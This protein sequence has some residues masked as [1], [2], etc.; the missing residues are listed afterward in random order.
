MEQSHR[1]GRKDGVVHGGGKNYKDC[2]QEIARKSFFR[3][4]LSVKRVVCFSRPESFLPS[5]LLCWFT[6]QDGGK[7]NR[8]NRGRKDVA[9]QTGRGSRKKGGD[10]KT[11]MP[12]GK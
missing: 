6:Q 11:Q 5:H 2:Q 4:A 3:K 9:V 1:R 10:E 7:I 12:T 8:W